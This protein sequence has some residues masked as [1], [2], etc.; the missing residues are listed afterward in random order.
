[1][2][3]L[4]DGGVHIEGVQFV[5]NG[6]PVTIRGVNHSGT[7]DYCVHNTGIFEGPTDDSLVTPMI[8]WGVNTVRL[9]LNEDCWLGLNGVPASMGGEAY[10]SA[11]EGVVAMIRAHGLFVIL[12]LSFSAPG[13]ILATQYQPMADMDHSVAFW[14]SVASTFGNDMGVMFDLYD[15]PN[16]DGT[17]A[18]S[19][20]WDCWLNGCSISIGRV[21]PGRRR[22]LACKRCSMRWWRLALRTPCW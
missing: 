3:A 4:A 11:I 5:A 13:S 14:T 2:N 10:R 9:P 15:Q 20:S 17:N 7:E 19:A 18:T 6:V 21:M 8:G 1:M 12:N 22:V 16:I